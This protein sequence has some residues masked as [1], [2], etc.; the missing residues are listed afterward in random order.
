M[1]GF[2]KFRTW[3][4]SF[5]SVR[6]FFEKTIPKEFTLTVHEF[7]AKSDGWKEYCVII[8]GS[9]LVPSLPLQVFSQGQ[10]GL[11]AEDC[12]EEDDEQILDEGFWL[13]LLISNIFSTL[14]RLKR[15]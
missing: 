9:D 12:Q 8:C 11:V 15:E 6:I 10:P 3:V 1:K 4:K 7:L 2:K 13:H 5:S 14:A